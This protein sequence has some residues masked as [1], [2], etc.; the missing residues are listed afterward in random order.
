MQIIDNNFF[1]NLEKRTYI[2]LG[3]FDGLHLGHMTL[4]K[5]CIQL[6]NE[7]NGNSM[8]YTFKNHPLTVVN[9]NITPKLIMNNDNKINILRSV[10][11]EIL[12]L[13]EFNKQIMQTTAEEFV[14]ELL[15][16]YNMGG[17]VVGFNYRFGHKNKGNVELLKELGTKYNFKVEVINPLDF[18]QELISS[19]RIRELIENGEIVEANKML[20]KPFVLSGSVISGKKLGRTLGYPTANM[21]VD[22][23]FIIPSSGVYYT[24][25]KHNDD[26]YIGMTNV[27]Y[28]P[29]IECTNNIN[30][31]TYILDFDKDIYGDNI[32]VYFLERIRDEVKFSS[33]RE[34]I[35]QMKK[36]FNY[37]K[38]KKIEEI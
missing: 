21:L 15:N 37:V 6:A 30:V 13:V 26:I 28:N 4:I 38:G 16:R 12:C 32:D 1:E 7:S 2:A 31:E 22:E 11:V 19:S 9:P 33:L 36:D 10:G 20:Y 29:T 14:L 3:S 35:E 34:L 5:K 18:E 27:G 8:V 23:K 25:V 24:N 17:V